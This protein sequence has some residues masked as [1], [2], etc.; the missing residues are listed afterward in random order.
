MSDKVFFSV[1]G[2]DVG[3]LIEKGLLEGDEQ[4][5]TSTS[6]K[7]T[8]W[9]NEL[10]SVISDAGGTIVMSGGD[11]LLSSID[12]TCIERVL[13]RLSILQQSFDFTCSAA[14]G[15]AMPEVY[16]A[17]KLAKSKGKN[18]FVS[19]IGEDFRPLH[20]SKIIDNY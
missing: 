18:H 6:Q 19:L 2:D 15:R 13:S 17:L 16:F 11:M 9:L 14:I 4:V 10:E 3:K 12:S 1:D 8:Q 7:I 20:E 5:L